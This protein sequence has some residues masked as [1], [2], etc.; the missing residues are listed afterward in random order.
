MQEF[1]QGEPSQEKISNKQAGIHFENGK[2]FL[3]LGG[4]SLNV[5]KIIGERIKN[6]LELENSMDDDMSEE[7]T[8]WEA[9]N[10]HKAVLYVLGLLE[11]DN[12]LDKEELA[13]RYDIK[14]F[15]DDNYQVCNNEEKLKDNLKRELEVSI[16]VIQEMQP[17]KYGDNWLVVHS[18]ICGVTD[19]GNIICFDKLN[20]QGSPFRVISLEDIYKP[21]SKYGVKKISN[22]NSQVLG[23][24]VSEYSELESPG[25]KEESRDNEELLDAIYSNTPGYPGKGDYEEKFKFVLRNR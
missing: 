24:K 14:F 9:F 8:L 16:G 21:G 12:M 15:E 18:A 5:P 10:C 4:E 13:K 1:K 2:Y 11:I 3:V 17:S 20:S 19:R 23:Q 7:L 25:V 22:I 6:L